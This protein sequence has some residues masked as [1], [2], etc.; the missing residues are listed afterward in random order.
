MKALVPIS[1]LFLALSL[2][3]CGGSDSSD[4]TGGGGDTGGG[5][6]EV[7]TYSET[8]EDV[9]SKIRYLPKDPRDMTKEDLEYFTDK[10]WWSVVSYTKGNMPYSQGNNQFPDFL[11]H[12]AR[13]LSITKYFVHTKRFAE[14]VEEYVID[15]PICTHNQ[16]GLSPYVNIE[17]YGDVETEDS[18]V[19]EYSMDSEGYPKVSK[20]M[21][22]ESVLRNRNSDPKVHLY[23]G[24][25]GKA[26]V[27]LR[28][29]LDFQQP[30]PIEWGSSDSYGSTVQLTNGNTDYRL[31]NEMFHEFQHSIG[32]SHPV[33]VPSSCKELT[34]L[35]QGG[36]FNQELDELSHHYDNGDLPD[37][38]IDEFKNTVIIN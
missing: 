17:T 14:G 22:F 21:A 36:K 25:G 9:M 18:S 27:G 29:L 38:Y 24:V 31:R 23:E 1:V 37:V 35:L 30:I 32:Y 19:L 13:E 5:G 4:N 12:M 8:I 6:V 11:V 16:V 10:S 28:P 20:V 7:L 15:K 2:S 26:N 3:G 33:S 34:H